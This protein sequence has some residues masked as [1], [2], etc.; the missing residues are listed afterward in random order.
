M[1]RLR[2][3]LP[4]D[5]PLL[6][7]EPAAGRGRG[8][9]EAGSEPGFEPGRSGSERRLSRCSLEHSFRTGF[10]PVR[11][12]FQ[13]GRNLRRRS[14]LDPLAPVA[15][16]WARAQ[17]CASPLGFVRVSS[18]GAGRVVVVLMPGPGDH[19]G[20]VVTRDARRCVAAMGLGARHCRADCLHRGAGRQT[21]PARR[22]DRRTCLGA[23][24]LQLDSRDRL[25]TADE[26]LAGRALVMQPP[27]RPGGYAFK[28][29]AIEDAVPVAAQALAC[30]CRPAICRR[31]E[32]RPET[33][34][35]FR[36]RS[37]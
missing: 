16:A 10:G 19:A 27:R 7:D 25:V 23:Y 8:G 35:R 32:H 11:T 9:G 14:N 18:D 5:D 37:R 17:I 20:A 31:G 2:K 33:G 12:G 36:P 13:A 26:F 28:A 34:P 15:D 21:G 30:R 3:Q 22:Q 1:D 4:K 29:A 6:K 24:D